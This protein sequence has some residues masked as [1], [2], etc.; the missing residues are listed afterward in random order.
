MSSVA[1][2]IKLGSWWSFKG[3]KLAVS[4]RLLGQKEGC[5]F[6]G[7]L[8]IGPQRTKLIPITIWPSDFERLIESGDIQE[9]PYE[10]AGR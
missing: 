3:Y 6:S 7:N 1:D 5:G 2:S 4:F 10:E 8:Y 9:A